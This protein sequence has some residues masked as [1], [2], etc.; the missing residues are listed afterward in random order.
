M[1]SE[2]KTCFDKYCKVCIASKDMHCPFHT[3]LEN[4]I[5]DEDL[6][7]ITDMID[8]FCKKNESWKEDLKDMGKDAIIAYVK[9]GVIAHS[10]VTGISITKAVEYLWH[11]AGPNSEDWIY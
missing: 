5:S 7:L 6:K 10:I 9:T 8:D 2:T 11:E 4:V 3:D 1:S